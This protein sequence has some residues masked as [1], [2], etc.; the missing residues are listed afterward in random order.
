MFNIQKYP[1]IHALA[2]FIAFESDTTRTRGMELHELVT[3]YYWMEM[4]AMV[5]YWTIYLVP[6]MSELDIPDD[7]RALKVS[8]HR[9]MT[10]KMLKDSK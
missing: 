3:K 4:W 5:Y 8:I 7:I 2:A 9:K 10:S 1:C 6:D